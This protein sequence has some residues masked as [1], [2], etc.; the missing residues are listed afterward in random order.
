MSFSVWSH[1]EGILFVT[2][3]DFG[4][5][6]GLSYKIG[7]VEYFQKIVITLKEK[8]DMIVSIGIWVDIEQILFPLFDLFNHES[9]QLTIMPNFKIE[10]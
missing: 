10:F 5:K 1:D 6:E 7:I 2:E 3:G 9:S 4:G 8:G